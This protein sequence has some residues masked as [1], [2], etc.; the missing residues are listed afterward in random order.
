MLAIV[1]CYH[2]DNNNKYV[3][4]VQINIVVFVTIAIY[5]ARSTMLKN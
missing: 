3:R 1:Y 5:E 4:K 2:I